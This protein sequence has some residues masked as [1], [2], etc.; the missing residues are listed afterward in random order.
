[1]RRMVV[2]VVAVFFAAAGL[3]QACELCDGLENLGYTKLQITQAIRSSANRAEAETKMRK[4]TTERPAVKKAAVEAKSQQLPTPSAVVKP[5]TA[6][7]EAT[8]QIAATPANPQIV[9]AENKALRFSDEV[10]QVPPDIEGR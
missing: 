1:M 8:R 6:K 9:T 3:V 4:M 2:L 7:T 10:I 5:S